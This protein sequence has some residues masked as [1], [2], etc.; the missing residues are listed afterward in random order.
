VV[1]IESRSGLLHARLKAAFAGANEDERHS[2]A[3]QHQLDMLTRKQA[4]RQG[5]QAQ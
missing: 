4:A 3:N 5:S 1:V 2:T